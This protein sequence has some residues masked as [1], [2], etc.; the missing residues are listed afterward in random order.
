MDSNWLTISAA[1]AQVGVAAHVLRHWEDEGVMTPARRPNG[2]RRYSREHL[3]QARLVR[4]GQAG[5]LS[6]GQ[7]R[8][9]LHDHGTDRRTL[10]LR[11]RQALQDRAARTAAAL[12]LVDHALVCDTPILGDCPG[13]HDAL[14]RAGTG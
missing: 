1:A 13:C 11:H 10:L 14:D 12:A 7:L 8:A 3:E 9:L 6:L 2:H 4:L 5:G